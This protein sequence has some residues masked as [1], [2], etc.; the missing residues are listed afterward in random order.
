M[1]GFVH[2]FQCI[3]NASQDELIP[4]INYKGWWWMIS[5]RLLNKD[6]AAAT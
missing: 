6:P 3:L 1:K 5:S 2:S 4:E